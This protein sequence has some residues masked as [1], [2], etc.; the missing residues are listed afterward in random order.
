MDYEKYHD[1]AL[2]YHK[3]MKDKTC[4]QTRTVNRILK[5]ISDGDI[6]A[7]PKLLSTLR[8]A[9]RDR[10]EA[11][12]RLEDLVNGF[13]GRQYMADGYFVEQMLECCKQL[14]VDAQGSFPSFEMFPC[15]VTVNPESQEVVIDRKRFQCLRPAKVVATIKNELDRLAKVSFNAAAFAKELASAYDLAL[16]KKAKGRSTFDAAGSCYLYDLYD[17]LTPM[18][19]HKREYTR[20]NYAYDLARL[21]SNEGF[22]L[23]DGRVFR[24]DTVRGNTK[25]IRI[26]DQHGTAQYIS[27]I[28]LLPR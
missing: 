28:R 12:C 23:D 27:S 4:L 21:Y 15:R 10:E 19:R 1:E 5:C 14:G 6:N 11:L 20:N 18:R 13:D 17:F 7:M 24:F 25:A 2:A 3:E 26:L 8:D 22:T 16:L 9:A